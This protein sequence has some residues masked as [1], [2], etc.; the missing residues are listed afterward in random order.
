[1]DLP[2]G[3]TILNSSLSAKSYAENNYDIYAYEINNTIVMHQNH[4]TASWDN[5]SCG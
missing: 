5:Q 1:T 3:Q 4:S 2:I